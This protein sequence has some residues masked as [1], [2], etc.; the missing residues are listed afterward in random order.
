LRGRGAAIHAGVIDYTVYPVQVGAFAAFMTSPHLLRLR[1][2]FAL[3][4][5]FVVSALNGNLRQPSRLL[6]YLRLLSDGAFGNFRQLLT[7]ITLNPRWGVTSTRSTT[8]G[9]P[10]TRTTRVSCS[11]SSRSA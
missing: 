6:P 7:D 11:S 8:I 1:V 3:N 2:L 9:P 10:R 4:Q 5:M